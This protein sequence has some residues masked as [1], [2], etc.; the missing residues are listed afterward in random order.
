MSMF[1]NIDLLRNF[2]IFSDFLK[3]LFPLPNDKNTFSLLN[4]SSL[5]DLESNENSLSVDFILFEIL[6]CFS[7]IFAPRATAA[8]ELFISFV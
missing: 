5:R 6:K 1:A 8:N 2:E 4:L 7:I 3:F